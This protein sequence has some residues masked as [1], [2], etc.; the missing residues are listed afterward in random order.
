ME[1]QSVP[2][3]ATQDPHPQCH[4][5]E[6]PQVPL[7]HTP[8]PLPLNLDPL[9]VPQ[10]TMSVPQPPPLVLQTA[11]AIPNHLSSLDHHHHQLMTQ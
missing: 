6:S 11:M 7:A 10:L 5:Q 1:G 2:H 9:Q 4:P 3:L 8:V